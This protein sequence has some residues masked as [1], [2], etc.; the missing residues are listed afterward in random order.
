MIYYAINLANQNPVQSAQRF[1]SE[2]QALNFLG[3]E[4]AQAQ[5][6][7]HAQPVAI[8]PRLSNTAEIVIPKSQA[9]M[10]K[11]PHIVVRTLAPISEEEENKP[12][13]TLIQTNNVKG[14]EPVNYYQPVFPFKITKVPEDRPAPIPQVI[15]VLNNQNYQPVPY[16]TFSKGYP[17]ET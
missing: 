10:R 5:G 11:E 12:K 7:L 13:T 4:P 14:F 3:F 6:T 17:V 8:Q 16:Y 15:K 9:I 1:L 2:D